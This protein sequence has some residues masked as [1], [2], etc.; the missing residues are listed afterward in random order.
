MKNF[1]IN[2]S[3]YQTNQSDIAIKST[4]IFTLYTLY[5]LTLVTEFDVWKRRLIRLS[6]YNAKYNHRRNKGIDCCA[7]HRVIIRLWIF[8]YGKFTR[9]IIYTKSERNF[10][11]DFGLFNHIHCLIINKKLSK[12]CKLF[13]I[14]IIFFCI[15]SF[16][17]V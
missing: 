2:I 15:F 4:F 13:L 9:A 12:I 10:Y 7:Q 5:T 1:E 8:I 17:I 3:F 11:S 6:C 16:F 14:L